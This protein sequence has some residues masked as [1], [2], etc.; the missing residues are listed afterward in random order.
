MDKE[1][2]YKIIYN[3]SYNPSAFLGKKRQEKNTFPKQPING[4]NKTRETSHFAGRKHHNCEGDAAG[5][6][7]RQVPGQPPAGER[8]GK[9]SKY[10]TMS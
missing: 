9:W 6:P 10:N 3:F 8:R 7:C 2:T 4:G 1:R 5:S